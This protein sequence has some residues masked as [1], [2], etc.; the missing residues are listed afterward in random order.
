MKVFVDERQREHDPQHFLNRGARR[1]SPEQPARLDALRK[2]AI[3][4]G[5][6]EAAPGD[7]GMAPLARVHSADYLSFLST[8]YEEW[9][10][11]PGASEEVVPNVHPARRPATYPAHPVGRAGWHQADTACPIGPHTYSSVYWSAQSA[12]SAADD[13]LRG[14]RANYALCRPPGHHAFADMAG[15]FCFLNNSGIAAAHLL[16]A[17]RRPA[18][19]D[20]DLH[21]GN[22]TQAMFYDR[23]D[24]LTVS[25]HIDPD[26]FY[27]FFW[28]HA[29]ERGEGLGAGYNLNLPLP[30]GSGDVP[31]LDALGIGLEQVAS[32]GADTLVVALGLD[33][34]HDDPFAGLT[35]TRDGFCRIAE[36]LA[37]TGLPAVLVQEGG[38]L[39]DALGDN[40]TAFLTSFGEGAG[41]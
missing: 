34:Y 4:A 2:G 10:A 9:Q 32:F 5:L 37:R 21:H 16:A 23:A 13:V 38:Y 11:L 39:S 3:A 27:P 30:Q 26:G 6:E 18:I 15:G 40:I 36:A 20:V 17:G 35:V 25:V 8:I 22:G 12:V 28:G 24:V 1:P 33:A 7:F 31:F 19:V 29:H 41:A 14:A